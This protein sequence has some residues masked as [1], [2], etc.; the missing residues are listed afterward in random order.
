MVILTDKCYKVNINR[1][2]T[3]LFVPIKTFIFD[4]V[5]I[6]GFYNVKSNNKFAHRKPYLVLCCVI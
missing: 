5:Y 2:C 4:H 1:C 6:I 3:L